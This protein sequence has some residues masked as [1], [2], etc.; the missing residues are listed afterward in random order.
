MTALI[1]WPAFVA[2]AISILGWINF[3]YKEHDNLSPRTLSELGAGSAETLAYFR[4]VL[5]ICGPLFGITMYFYVIPL[6]KYGP[7]HALAWSITLLGEILLGVFPA[8]G[9]TRPLHDSL[10]MLMGLGMLATSYL[11]WL[12][13]QGKPKYLELCIAIVMT[14]LAAY[15]V[16]RQKNF[17]VS[18]LSFIFLSHCSI[19]IAALA[20][21]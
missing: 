6:I 11:C 19:L 12:S 15:T 16:T 21:T 5:W 4:T 3:I 1:I 20:L 2:T 10:A 9:K 18:E 17:I 7:Y 14:I 13:L 8:M